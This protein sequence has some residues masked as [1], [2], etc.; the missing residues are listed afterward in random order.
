MDNIPKGYKKTEI[1]V[2]PEKWEVLSLN[3]IGTFSKGRGI[4]RSEANSGNIPCVRYGEIYTH[5]NDY[6][7]NFNSRISKYVAKTS[8][9]M[10]KGDLLFSGS[11]ETKEEIGKCVAFLDDVEAYAGGD[12]VVLSP[13]KGDSLYFG[14]LLNSPFIVK[15]KSSRGQ[16]DA[17]VH[18]SAN[19]LSKIVIPYPEKEEQKQIGLTLSDIDSLITSLEKLIEKKKFIK[20]GVMQELL[21]GKRRLKGFSGEWKKVKLGDIAKISMGQS[22]LSQYYN[23][24]SIGLPLIQGNA[25]IFNRVTIV[26]TYTSNI[27]KRATV[28]DIIMTVRAPV[29]QIAEATFDSCIGRGVCAITYTNKFLYHYLINL[30]NNWKT[31]STGSTFDSV[32]SEQV[33]GLLLNIPKDEDEQTAI[34]NILSDLD[35]EIESLK[36]KHSKLKTIKDGAMQQLLTGKIRLI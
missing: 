10:I 25:D 32:N 26:R 28:G 35:L 33:K 19:S 6:I 16:G 7:R 34:A 21:T 5:H 24:K 31:Y 11:G 36:T 14:Y 18:I 27:T 2:I 12:I 22:P 30:E 8:K 20:Q 17:I 13:N 9:K 29:G 15:Q 23:H 1:G 4:S 3:D